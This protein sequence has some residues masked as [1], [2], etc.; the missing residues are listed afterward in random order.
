MEIQ[1]KSPLVAG[2]INSGSGG[3][4]ITNVR[5]SEGYEATVNGSNITVMPKAAS[6]HTTVNAVILDRE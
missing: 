6:P 3:G 5:V 4:A 1:A 2:V